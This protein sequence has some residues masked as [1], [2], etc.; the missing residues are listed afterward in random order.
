MVSICEAQKIHNHFV[1]QKSTILTKYNVNNPHVIYFNLSM[2]VFLLPYS[3]V[4]KNP[5]QNCNLISNHIIQLLFPKG[6]ICNK[7]GFEFSLLFCK[8]ET[9]LLKKINKWNYTHANK[10]LYMFMSHLYMFISSLIEK[11]K[12][13]LNYPTLST[14]TK[15]TIHLSHIRPTTFSNE[16]CPLI[17][18]AIFRGNRGVK[19]FKCA[20]C[21]LSGL[22]LGLCWLSALFHFNRWGQRWNCRRELK[23]HTSL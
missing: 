23:T 17:K 16:T 13:G 18:Y 1:L 19:A 15:Q 22:N 4:F 12:P 14:S 5:I 2:T 7:Q 10:I 21:R 20:H 9:G 6:S 3:G 8:Q 11:V